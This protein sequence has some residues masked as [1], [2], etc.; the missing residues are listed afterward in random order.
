MELSQFAKSRRGGELIGIVVLAAGI[1]LSAALLS[2]HPNDSS[3]FFTSTNSAIANWIG[4]YGATIAWIFVGFFGF[5]S[6][7]FPS[8]LLLSGWNRFWGK[9]PKRHGPESGNE[10]RISFLDFSAVGP[11]ASLGALALPPAVLH[12]GPKGVKRQGGQGGV[13]GEQH[14]GRNYLRHTAEGRV[15]QD[16]FIAAIALMAASA[17]P[18]VRAQTAVRSGFN[19]FSAQQDVEIGRQSAS[20]IEQQL[21]MVSDPNVARY[22][23]DLHE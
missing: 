20:Q 3:A 13:R 16:G 23:Y 21:P 12:R 6:L 2:Y 15:A 19:V 22:E 10:E 11:S 7:L 14:I 4:Y 8:S 5:A 18:M 17:A 9:T 1:G